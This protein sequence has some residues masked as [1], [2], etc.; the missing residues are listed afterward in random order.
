M[1]GE[2]VLLFKERERAVGSG[3]VR[4]QVRGGKR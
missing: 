1:G 2:N 3:C 4:L